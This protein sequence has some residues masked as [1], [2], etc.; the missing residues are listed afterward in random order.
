MSNLLK[1]LL[2]LIAFLFLVLLAAVIIIPL[3]FDPNDYKDDIANAVKEETGR[4]LVISEPIELS[5]F[6]WIGLK[7]GGVSLSNAP[8]MGEKPL[9]QIEE[10]DLKV[11]FKP[12]FN[13]NIVVDTVVVNG[14]QLDL[15]Q[16]EEGKTNWQDL[17]TADGAA[18]EKEEKPHVEITAK[19]DM[20]LQVHGVELN[21]ARINFRDLKSGSEYQA[22]E[23]NFTV[24][25]Y[26]FGEPVPV[27]GSMVL[28]SKADELELQLEMGGE[29]NLT[30]DMQSLLIN[31]LSLELVARGKD[32][33]AEGI[34]VN[35]AA[36]FGLDMP[37]ERLELEDLSL[38][39]PD[40]DLIGS[41]S[42]KG[43]FSQLVASGD[44]ELKHTDIRKQLSDL[45]VDIKTT[46]NS[47]LQQLTAKAHWQY[48]DQGLTAEPLQFTLDDS[49]LSGR[50]KVTDFTKPAVQFQLDID[51]IDLDR[52]MP[53]PAEG[54]APSDSKTETAGAGKKGT[55]ENPFVALRT[56]DLNGKLT[57][58]KLV[59]AKARMENVQVTA[60]SR[61]GV[62]TLKPVR[63]DLYQG[64]VRGMAQLDARADMPKYRV[65][66]KLQGINI[67]P[68]LKDLLG[69]ERMTGT[70]DVEFKTTTRG[71]TS[72][73][74]TGNLNGTLSISLRDGSYKGVNIAQTVRQ[75]MA[76][77]DGRQYV[78]DEPK[79]T[80]FSSLT[81]SAVITNGVI[82]NKD[83]HL[84]S[85]LLRI[86]GR[87]NMDLNKEKVNYLLTTELVGTLEGQ[88]GK[89]A[90]E[91][92]GVA[93]PVRLKGDIGSPSPSVDVQAA[94]EA[95]AKKEIEAQ[96]EKAI[97]KAQKKIEE[98]FGSKL[99]DLFR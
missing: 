41:V 63:A 12:L 55:A 19:T 13:K 62:L 60:S 53:P 92:A 57:I 72:A 59:V 49:N 27:S 88:G 8:G 42:V 32:L 79:Q 29:V 2:G 35:L 84:A 64:D 37:S 52:Y 18:E 71:V 94:L 22:D 93:I 36:D 83:L 87:G 98:E 17:V 77:Y 31:G 69:E 65:E 56:L 81:G 68:L 66:N 26:G 97:E 21:D 61:N 76:L 48:S 58:G 82:Y 75:A 28:E 47:V 39:A 34:S 10:I 74:Q 14:L 95:N 73:Q 25:S 46:D 38:S 16:D 89:S 9:A 99:K 80:D 44:L 30:E 7:L 23:L 20:E 51:A 90:S 86:E 33:P 5:L 6:P 70:G 91:L 40:L 4:D 96:K 24:G 43:L 11:A 78:V 15:V 1:W 50:I 54:E 85:P 67:G 3:L 45:G